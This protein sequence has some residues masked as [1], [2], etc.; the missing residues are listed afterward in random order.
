MTR[1]GAFGLL[2]GVGWG[3]G[4]TD[5]LAA[6]HGFLDLRGRGRERLEQDVVALV[7]PGLPLLMH[8]RS[9]LAGPKEDG[10]ACAQRWYTELEYYVDRIVLPMLRTRPADE[11]RAHVIALVDAMVAAEQ[12]R[13]AAE[14]LRTPR[15]VTWRVDTGWAG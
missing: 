1:S 13:A 10:T 11:E 15:P 3:H 6:I 2:R 9:K 4:F 12:A 5:A 14:A 8:K 7:E